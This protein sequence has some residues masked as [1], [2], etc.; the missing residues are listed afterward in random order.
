MLMPCSEKVKL[1][2]QYRI[3]T[4][5]YSF[6]VFELERSVQTS[7]KAGF[8]DLIRLTLDAR[9]VSNNARKDLQKHIA[10]HRC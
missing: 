6:A 9:E 10:E 3:A 5:A 8:D 4:E 2:A 7:N 1:T